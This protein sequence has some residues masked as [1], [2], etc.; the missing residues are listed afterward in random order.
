MYWRP[1]ASATQSEHLNPPKPTCMCLLDMAL[2]LQEALEEARRKEATF[3]DGR[4]RQCNEGR[5]DFHM[6]EEDGMGNC[7]LR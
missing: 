7:V 4:V 2:A 3:A 5:V 1:R 6:N